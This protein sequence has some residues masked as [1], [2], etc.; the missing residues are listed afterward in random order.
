[1]RA[2]VKRVGEAWEYLE[3]TILAG[4]K[5]KRP[6]S[7]DIVYK[8]RG[9]KQEWL[10][11]MKTW[12]KEKLDALD[13]ALTEKLDVFSGKYSVIPRIKRWDYRGIFGRDVKVPN[14]GSETDPNRMAKRVQLL[15]DAKAALKAVDSTLDL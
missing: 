1:M 14:C 9:L 6:K 8:E 11:F 15:K 4:T 7:N 12:H 13:K 3:R 2:Q 10:D 5:W